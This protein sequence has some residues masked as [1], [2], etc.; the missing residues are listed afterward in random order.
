L[1]TLLTAADHEAIVMIAASSW[2]SNLMI[3]TVSAELDRCS[4]ADC[5][6]PQRIPHTN[7]DL[8]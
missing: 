1:R 3:N 7:S 4:V 2:T 8:P 5:S 6:A